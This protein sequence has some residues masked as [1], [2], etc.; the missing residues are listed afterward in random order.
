MRCGRDCYSNSTERSG[1]GENNN[2]GEAKSLF[3]FFF[4]VFSVQWSTITWKSLLAVT[5]S[6]SIM[7]TRGSQLLWKLCKGSAERNILE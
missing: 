7:L 5:C 2:G 1:S 6:T 4:S 3:D